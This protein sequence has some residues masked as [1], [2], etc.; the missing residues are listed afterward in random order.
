MVTV[1]RN[2][3]DKDNPIY[4]DVYSVLG[5]VRDGIY[6]D[7]I[8]LLRQE[9]DKSE[10]ERIKR[11][12]LS[13][14]FSGK[15]KRRFDKDIISHSGLAVLDFDHIDIS[16]KKLISGDPYTFAAF[17]SP[18][19]D[20][21]KV[22]VRIPPEIEN[23][24]AYYL[25]IVKYCENKKYPKLDTTSKN[26]SRVCFISY[27]PDIYINK[28]SVV[29]DSK[30]TIEEKTRLVEQ[31]S[32]QTTDFAKM[33]VVCEMVRNSI[34]GNKH[35]E[36]VKAS[37]LAGGFIAGGLVEEHEAIR[38]LEIEIN[39]KDPKDFKRAAQ[40]ITECIEYGKKDPIYEENYRAK[41]K[42][43]K[44]TDIIIEDRPAKDVIFLDEVKDKILYSFKHGTSQGE[45]TH[46]PQIDDKYRMKRGELTLIHGIA[47]HGKSA[48]LRQIMLAKSLHDGYK[49]GIFSPEDMP[50]EEFYK[51]L[52]HSY[53]GKSTEPH[54][55]NQMSVG[56]LEQGMEFIKNHF[57]LIYPKDEAP[58]PQYINNR[59]REL[60]IKNDIDGCAIDPYNQLDNDI[61]KTGGREDQY[62]SRFLTDSKRFAV[63]HNLFYFIV[64]HPRGG[65]SKDGS[66]YE[67][68]NV[69]DLAGG[70]MWNNKCDNILV[71]H[72]PRY[73][74]DKKDTRAIFA[75]QK[76]K[77][78]KLNGV[79]GEVELYF[80]WSEARF[81]QT[82]DQYSPLDPKK[83]ELT[84]QD[85]WS[86]VHATEPAPF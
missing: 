44:T 68:P 15:F 17:I 67:M 3:F 42:E 21:L 6:K 25:G 43:V 40:T 31:P 61:S 23:H 64:A 45:S 86:Q 8:H 74:S 37:R 52:I 76:I 46:F 47:N 26:I 69:Y 56:E 78:Q 2:I 1:F 79:P 75:S 32:A 29:F 62:L 65:L 60:V 38:L 48:M 77:K 5:A 16:F 84:Q 63:E 55:P 59:F 10:R 54:H 33:N 81:R 51:D 35:Q 4:R 19:G 27:D 71:H 14:C 24:E 82:F 70:A 30:G 72:R 57:F 13:I 53:I 41:L 85:F 50:V 20:G 73:T 39:R 58:T 28:D 18:S 9:Q 12:L 34:D 80:I 22:L 49:W 7:K 36:L 83:Q 11:G 66:D